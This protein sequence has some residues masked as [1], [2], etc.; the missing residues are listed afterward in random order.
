MDPLVKDRILANEYLR[1]DHDEVIFAQSAAAGRSVDPDDPI[2]H[3][4]NRPFIT[5]NVVNIFLD[6]TCIDR[7]VVKRY[8]LMNNCGYSEVTLESLI[9]FEGAEFILAYFRPIR[10]V[11]G[12][13]ETCGWRIIFAPDDDRYT[14]DVSRP[15][16]DIRHI[17]PVE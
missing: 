10:N 8:M 4:P 6:D 11:R 5:G 13:G 7:C 16:Y 14:Y 1:G 17:I 12:H 15:V 2:A 9:R 3:I